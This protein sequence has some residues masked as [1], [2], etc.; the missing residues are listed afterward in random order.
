MSII[1][2]LSTVTDNHVIENNYTQQ[3][4]NSRYGDIVQW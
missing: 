3:R 1:V 4:Y 2:L